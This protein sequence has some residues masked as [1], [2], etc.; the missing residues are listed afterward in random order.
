MRILEWRYSFVKKE[1]LDK[2]Y[3]YFERYGGVTIVIARF[4]PF[5]RTFAPFLAGVGKM[6]Y[7]WFI[8]YNVIGGVAWVGAFLA[9]GF[10]F[11]NLPLVKQ[12]FSLIISVIIGLSLL[13]FVSIFFSLYRSMKSPPAAEEKK[14]EG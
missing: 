9:A 4:M 3:E 7:S 1:H 12:N 14:R 6:R 8:G 11:G 5:I 2:T 10:L 13:A